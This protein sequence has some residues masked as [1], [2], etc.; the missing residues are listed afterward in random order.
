MLP[1]T[2]TKSVRSGSRSSR[3]SSVGTSAPRGSASSTCVAQLVQETLVVPH[4]LPG[5]EAQGERLQDRERLG[6]RLRA[7]PRA[8]RC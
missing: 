8:R 2:T 6:E 7:Q 5:R 4:L 1:P 3:T